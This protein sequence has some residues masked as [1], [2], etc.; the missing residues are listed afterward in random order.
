M[1]IR[2]A[3]LRRRAGRGMPLTSGMVLDTPAIRDAVA[4]RVPADEA[5]SALV[6]REARAQADDMRADAVYARKVLDRYMRWRR[7]DSEREAARQRAARQAVR[8]AA[9]PVPLT[10]GTLLDALGLSLEAAQHM[11][12]PYCS[13]DAFGEEPGRCE[14]AADLGLYL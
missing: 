2:L 3:S 8:D 10:L 11:V 12:Q 1:Q 13:C 6:A 5:W 14:H 9:E 4:R 7:F